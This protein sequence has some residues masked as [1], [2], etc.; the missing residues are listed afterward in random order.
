MRCKLLTIS[1]K[2]KYA[3]ERATKILKNKEGYIWC[4]GYRHFVSLYLLTHL[5]KLRFVIIF[6]DTISAFA[7][8][9]HQI[10]FKCSSNFS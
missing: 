1:W 2:Q 5:N 3:R 8:I 7:A 6:I 10:V 9:T 4:Y